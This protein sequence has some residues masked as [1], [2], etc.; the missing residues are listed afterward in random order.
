MN[1]AGIGGGS[2]FTS[3]LDRWH[4]II[5]VNLWGVINGVNRFLPLMLGQQ[6]RCA[7]VNTGSQAGHHQSTPAIPPTQFRKP[8]YER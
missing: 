4:R 1:N 3:G 8:V 2:T 7:S 6:T 5:D